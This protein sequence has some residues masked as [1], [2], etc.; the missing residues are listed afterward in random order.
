MPSSRL[1]RPV[2][3]PRLALFLGPP[4]TSHY[5]RGALCVERILGHSRMHA[6]P[7]QKQK[8]GLDNGRQTSSEAHVLSSIAWRVAIL[9]TYTTRPA[10]P[11]ET[12]KA[13]PTYTTRGLGGDKLFN[14]TREGQYLYEDALGLPQAAAL[15]SATRLAAKNNGAECVSMAAA[16]HLRARRL[17][18]SATRFSRRP[19]CGLVAG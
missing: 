18:A 10:Q 1:R 13:R 3:H 8:S 6:I 16:F 4:F 2:S 7:C 14:L 15:S 17:T 11:S 5:G 9:A 12:L 19:P